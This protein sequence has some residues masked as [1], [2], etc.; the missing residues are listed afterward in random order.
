[1][2]LTAGGEVIGL[3]RLRQR[4]ASQEPGPSALSEASTS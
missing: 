4:W 1:V 2:L 3:R